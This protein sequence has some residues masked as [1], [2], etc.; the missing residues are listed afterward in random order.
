MMRALL[1]KFP[2]P[3]LA[4]VL[5]CGCSSSEEFNPDDFGGPIATIA[6]SGIQTS[7]S[8]VD[9]FFV[10]QVG[11]KEVTT[12]IDRTA[13]NNAGMGFSVRPVFA[14]HRVPAEPVTVAIVGRTYY[15]APVLSLANT[16]YE[17]KG[18]VKFTP[19]PNRVYRV[20]GALTPDYS[21]VWIEEEATGKPVTRKIEVHGSA[22][23][24]LFS[25]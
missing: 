18:K 22:A 14:E 2:A 24:G 9:F 21:A 17:V 15:G 4:A 7:R 6:D 3:A 16:V 8:E 19:L 12:S 1:M 5:L 10:S 13:Q 11:G 25:K 23:L 20:A